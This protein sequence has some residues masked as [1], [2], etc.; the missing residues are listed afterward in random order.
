MDINT[1]RSIMTVLAFA[2][3]VGIVMWA[4]SGRAKRGFDAAAALPFTEDES[5]E[6]RP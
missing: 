1:L 5:R 6:E 3:F 4:W 2:A